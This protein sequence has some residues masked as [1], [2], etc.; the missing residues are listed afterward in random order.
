MAAMRDVPDLARQKMTVASGHRLSLKRA[1]GL[2][3]AA[4]KRFY[5][6]NI[7]AS[8]RKINVIGWFDR[9]LSER[10]DGSHVLV[11]RLL[12]VLDAWVNPIL[13]PIPRSGDI[14]A[15]AVCRVLGVFGPP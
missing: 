11:A 10:L 12:A 1:F 5:T 2:R 15:I 8:F 14:D 3:K 7:T 4:S 13:V 9:D 6:P